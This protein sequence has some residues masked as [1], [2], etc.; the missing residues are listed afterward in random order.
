MPSMA[1]KPRVHFPEALYQVIA[2]RNKGQRVFRRDADFKLYLKM[3]GESMEMN[4]EKKY[5]II[6]A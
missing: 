4:L 5:F 3:L 6:I 1:R 2:R